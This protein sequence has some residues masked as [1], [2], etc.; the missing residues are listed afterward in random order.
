MNGLHAAFTG[1]L[2]G[3]P[4][5]RYTRTGKALLT[6]SVAVDENTTDT[7]DRA[8]P[9]THWVRV[10]ARED[11]ALSLAERL[12]KGVPVYIGGR[13]RLDRWTKPD[14]TE[15]SGLS[16][17]AWTVVPMGVGRKSTKG[18]DGGLPRE[19][20]PTRQPVVVGPESPADDLEALPF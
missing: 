18:L 19:S 15:R 17:S 3:E 1:R 7:E 5:Q 11:L 14:G 20:R 13:L 12:H 16:V 6:F 10:T 2:G 9:E 8:A 4:E